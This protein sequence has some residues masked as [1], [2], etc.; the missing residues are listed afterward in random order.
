MVRRGRKV[1]T[2]LMDASA[3][4]RSRSLES[5]P[6]WIPR[7]S[8]WSRWTYIELGVAMISALAA[9]AWASAGCELSHV[10]SG[11]TLYMTESVEWREPQST[12]PKGYSEGHG[13]I[14]AMYET[15]ELAI[16][17]GTLFKETRSAEISICVGCGFS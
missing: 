3:S 11:A 5:C 14:V 4:A 16:V 8:R 17:F 15:G 9:P 12:D 2:L 6:R 13:A 7:K 1:E 10:A